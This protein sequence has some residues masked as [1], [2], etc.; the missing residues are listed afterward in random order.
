[1][2]N[3]TSTRASRDDGYGRSTRFYTLPDGET[4][5]PSVTSILSA[6]NKPALVPW[7]AKVE[8][9]AVMGAAGNRIVQLDEIVSAKFAAA[10]SAG[11]A[12]T[13]ICREQ[14][15]DGTSSAVK[16]KVLRG[17]GKVAE[18]SLK[19]RYVDRAPPAADGKS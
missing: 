19:I 9:E 2:R 5:Y 14:P 4:S 3:G 1:M 15:M 8:R 17:E 18:I 6:V 13:F 12:L 11:D 10:V 16:A 7:A